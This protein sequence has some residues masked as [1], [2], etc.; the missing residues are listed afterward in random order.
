[1]RL[2]EL[3]SHVRTVVSGDSLTVVTDKNVEKLYLERCV[4][5]LGNAGFDVYTFVISPG[6]E[7]KDGKTYLELVNF[8]AGIPLT[9]ADG[10]IALG[11]GVVGDLAGFAAATYLRGIKVVQVPTTLLAA[12]DSSVGGKTAINLETGKNLV[13]AFHQPA[14]VWCDVDLLK[15]LPDDVY[16][17]G[18]A[19]VIKYGVIADAGLFRLLTDPKQAKKR[20]EEIIA[21]CVAI[22]K[23][24][25][26]EDEF[27]TGV[28]Q[29]L[30]FGHTIGHAVEKASGYKISHGKAVAKGMAKIAEISVR[31]GWCS[32]ETEEQIKSMLD[33]Y[34]FDLNIAYG[35]DV[36]YDI[37]KADKKRKGQL[38]DIV[39]PKEIGNCCLKRLTTEKLG[40]IL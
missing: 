4:Q 24:F 15:T 33:A 17:D 12:V 11:G 19:E 25:V 31:Q 8:L 28:R 37:M 26:E 36:L 32:V 20:L 38:I 9:R 5:S 22:K 27:D 13:G 35:K 10:L 1:M 3:G 14:L 6:E 21:S 7:S 39:V 29:M 40:D 16:Q 23:R 34:G 18:M 30:N 2:E